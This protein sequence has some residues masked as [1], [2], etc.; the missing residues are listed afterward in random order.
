MW[1]KPLSPPCKDCTLGL[2]V[3]VYPPLLLE[4]EGLFLEAIK[5]MV[6]KIVSGN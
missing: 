5:E 3:S 6:K 1:Y 4:G 2:L